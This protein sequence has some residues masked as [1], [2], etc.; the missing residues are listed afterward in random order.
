MKTV[1]RRGAP[2]KCCSGISAPARLLS[3]VE[4]T[5]VLVFFLQA[6]RGVFSGMFAAMYEAIFSHEGLVL[7]LLAAGVLVVFCFLPAMLPARAARS[8]FELFTVAMAVYACRIFLVPDQPR[9]TMFS[10]L[11]IFAATGTYMRGRDRRAEFPMGRSLLTAIVVDMFLRIAGN[12][13]DITFRQSWLPWQVVISGALSLLSYLLFRARQRADAGTASD[14][15]WAR[16]GLSLGALLFLQTSLLAMPNAVAR[17]SGVDYSWSVPV[18]LFCVLFPMVFCGGRTAPFPWIISIRWMRLLSVIVATGGVAMGYTTRGAAALVALGLAQIATLFASLCGSGHLNAEVNPCRIGWAV[19]LA[20]LV[21]VVLNVGWAFVFGH[22]YVGLGFFRQLGLPIFLLAT[23]IATW[24]LSRPQVVLDEGLRRQAK[25]SIPGAGIALALLSLGTVLALPPGRSHTMRD[26]TVRFGTYN[27]HYGYN[28]DWQHTLADTAETIEKSGADV[29]FLQE[30]DACRITSYGVD[31]AT[32]LAR[33]LRMNAAYQSTMAHLTGIATLSRFPIIRSEGRLLPSHDEQSA[34]LLTQLR[35]G[36]GVVNAYG[37]WL[38]LSP[39]ERR[40]QLQAA[41]DFIGSAPAVLGGDMNVT[42]NEPK[43][44]RDE[45]QR[46]RV[47]RELTRQGFE[48]PFI[49]GKFCPAPTEPAVRPRKRLDYVW[50]RG[51]VGH[52]VKAEVLPST[53]SDHR[54]VVVEF[55]LE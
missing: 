5:A 53:A 38:G 28:A 4:A 50:I 36:K 45:W 20:F 39:A 1:A 26:R 27:I 55:A 46:T 21:L 6:L 47:Y 8:P 18:M 19:S 48:D 44:G 17:W 25:L 51:L 12:T 13:Y 9:L 3:H 30:V 7:A 16:N 35:I 24:P 32:W 10:S 22:A 14:I 2:G 41:L 29:V 52:A 34:I 31:T 15:F 23:V 49:E 37:T 42:V 33:K 43:T 40:R 54:M 11:L